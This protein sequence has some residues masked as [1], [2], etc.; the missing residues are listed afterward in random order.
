MLTNLF[1]WTAGLGFL[2]LAKIKHRLQGYTPKPFG[3]EDMDRCIKYDAAIVSKWLHYLQEYSPS[4]SVGGKHILE[5][6][7]GS[8]LGCGVLL[9]TKGASYHACDVNSLATSVPQEFYTKIL[10]SA[11]VTM[12]MEQAM[13][14]V[15]YVVRDDF[16]FVAAFG[17]SFMDFVFSNA[18]FE[19]FDDIEKTVARMSK[20]CKDGA[21]LVA[22]I[23][24]QTHS[25]WIR[26]KDP[27]NIYRFSDFIYNLF[28]FRGQPN[29]KRPFEYKEALER[30]GWSDVRIYV[31]SR[32]TK[33]A[34]LAARFSDEKNEMENIVIVLCAKKGKVA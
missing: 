9:A 15:Q 30:N 27:N 24:M 26:E 2:A 23:D 17:E 18:A 25:R 16:D 19:H 7:P 33:K 5:L 28:Y 4:S 31:K 22:E 1:Y 32:T 20:V 11:K 34:G 13:E 8:D 21:I 3:L 10:A 29:R 14:Q 12:P 6:G